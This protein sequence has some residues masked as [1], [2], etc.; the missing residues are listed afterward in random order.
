MVLE[1]EKLLE[2][3][4]HGIA[5]GDS[6]YTQGQIAAKYI[7]SCEQRKPVYTE[8][9]LPDYPTLYEKANLGGA[10]CLLNIIFGF[11]TILGI[12]FL[13]SAL[14][15]GL[16]FLGL[17][18]GLICCGLGISFLIYLNRD[19]TTSANQSL[20]EAY[21]SSCNKIREENKESKAN[22]DKLFAVWQTST[23][24]GLKYIQERL[25]ESKKLIDEFFSVDVI[26]P[27]YR[28][29]PALTSI[30]EYLSSG[31]CDEL[32]GPNGA[33]N[34]YEAETRQNIIITQLDTIISDLDQIK[35]NQY[36][37]YQELQK[38]Q[39]N[40]SKITMDI[41]AIRGYTYTI[42]ELSSLNL[43]YNSVTAA[44]TS[45]LAFLET[46]R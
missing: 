28:S 36:I 22:Y 31:R 35:Q 19:H 27:K 45:A 4:Q 40:L 6:V 14:S 46:I 11:L 37:L 3:L 20:L 26:Y 23:Q 10:G 30:Y 41:S 25:E 38:I 12:Y 42:T 17:L 5:L 15:A 1:K 8:K 16:V 44:N 24:E 13:F 7:A 32:T 43:Y 34:I 2:Y 29:L 9:K 21:Q 33:Y 18:L 39:N